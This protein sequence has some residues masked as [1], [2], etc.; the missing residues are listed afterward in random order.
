M[1]LIGCGV[2]SIG[3][4]M[5][6]VDSVEFVAMCDVYDRNAERA[7]NKLGPNA[8]IFKDFRV[9]LEEMK[10]VD[11]VLIGTPDHWHA[12]ISIPALKAGK[13]VYCEK[14]IER[15]IQEGL[16]IIEATKKY[17][18]CIFLTGTQHRSAPHIMRAAE[19]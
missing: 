15:T 4:S 8:K 2:R 6:Q 12:L 3:N 19:S 9:L 16:E 10:D 5:N 17:P 14:P 18:K 13:H 1:A 7:K 11:A